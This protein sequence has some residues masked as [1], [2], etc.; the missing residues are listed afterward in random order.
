MNPRKARVAGTR[1]A[2][3]KQNFILILVDWRTHARIGHLRY[4]SRSWAFKNA[5]STYPGR[6]LIDTISR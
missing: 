5:L 2:G 1:N 4:H 3:L 6:Q